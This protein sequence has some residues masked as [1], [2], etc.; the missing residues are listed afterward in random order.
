M[1]R[2]ITMFAAT[3]YSCGQEGPIKRQPEDAHTVSL[4]GGWVC[5]SMSEN[6]VIY[7]CPKCREDRAP[8]ITKAAGAAS[9]TI[10]EKP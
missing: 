2:E 6:I 8:A 9:G 3:C 7:F 4:D 5:K 10:G 1:M